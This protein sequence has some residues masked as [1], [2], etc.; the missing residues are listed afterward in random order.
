MYFLKEII[1]QLFFGLMPLVMF[2]IYYRDQPRNYS[3]KF[4]VITSMLCLFFSMTFGASAVSGYFYDIRYIIMFFGMIFGGIHTGLILLAE[5]V[6]YRLYLGGEGMWVAMAILTVTF[7]LSILLYR[8]YERAKRKLIITITAGAFFSFVPIVF[9]YMYNPQSILD[10][11]VFHIFVVPIQNLLGCW[12]LISL[13]NKAVLDKQLFIEYA[14]NERVKAIG[15]VA[16]SLVHE[17]RNPLTAIK[18]FLTLMRG[19]RL[20][21]GKTER[22]IDICMSEI[23]RTEYI[24]SEYLSISKP[25]SDEQVPSDLQAILHI[26]RDVMNPYA[27]LNNVVLEIESPPEPVWIL[28]NPDRMKQVL[29]NFIKNAVEACADTPHGDGRVALNLQISTRKVT[30]KISDNGVGMTQEQLNHLGSIYFSTKSSGTGL[31]MTFS[32]QAVHTFGGTISVESTQGAGTEFTIKLPL[33]RKK[34]QGEPWRS[35]VH[36]DIKNKDI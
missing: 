16:A 13:F 33:Y 8:L 3:Q 27:N 5:F 24:L 29:V 2:N 7:P 35:G 34:E 4:I 19:S 31:G 26:T 20:E 1:L 22:Y 10:H 15:H 11:L 32:Y 28:A 9:V 36:I 6:L 30:L 21:P 14:Q 23:E 12:L 18:G 25:N 17:V